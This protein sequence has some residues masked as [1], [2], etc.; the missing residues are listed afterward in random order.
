MSNYKAKKFNDKMFKIIVDGFAQHKIK[1]QNDRNFDEESDG[2]D[3]L[4]KLIL[5]RQ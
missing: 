2:P 1:R 5:K 4:K 3:F